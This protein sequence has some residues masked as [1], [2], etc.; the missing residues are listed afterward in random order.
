MSGT[1]GAGRPHGFDARERRLLAAALARG[2]PLRCPR[3]DVAL[4]EQ[5]IEPQTGLPYVRRRLWVLCPQCRGTASLDRP[6][7]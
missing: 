7:G 2:E 6:Q 1:A 5:V 3:C 4:S